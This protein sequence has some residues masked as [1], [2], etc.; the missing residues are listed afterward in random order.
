[1]K[2]EK[3]ARMHNNK[4]KIDTLFNKAFSNSEIKP[5]AKLWE[6]IEKRILLEERKKRIAYLTRWGAGLFLLLL[7]STGSWLWFNSK[8]AVLNGQHSHFD[9]KEKTTVPTVITE[10]P[11]NTNSIN[12]TG[13]IIENN[14]VQKTISINKNEK[15]NSHYR[16]VNAPASILFTQKREQSPEVPLKNRN[17]ISYDLVSNNENQIEIDKSNHVEVNIKMDTSDDIDITER[18]QQHVLNDSL[19]LKNE[20]AISNDSIAVKK[21]NFLLSMNTDSVKKSDYSINEDIKILNHAIPPQWCLG[22]SYSPDYTYQVFKIGDFLLN[23]A[24]AQ[25]SVSSQYQY[26]ESSQPLYSYT[27]GIQGGY[28]INTKLSFQTGLHYSSKGEKTMIAVIDSTSSGGGGAFT[29][30]SSPVSPVVTKSDQQVIYQYKFIDV[31]LFLRY[32]TGNSSK[33]SS[34]TSAGV[35]LNFFQGYSAILMRDSSSNNQNQGDPPDVSYLRKMGY[36]IFISTG[37][38]YKITSKISLGGEPVFTYSLTP[39]RYN[40]SVK[41]Y[42]YSFGLAI[43]FRLYM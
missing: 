8:D 1:M 30:T 29:T 13:I 28:L 20:V 25:L 5:S 7:I 22:L 18:K 37:I 35:S 14:H 12:N 41:M 34:V 26:I 39:L 40:P 43:S 10:T 21:Q 23:H 27:F 9:I 38:E 31:P 3:L 24:P 2:N 4:S 15:D 33:I 19:I 16:K 6:N 32:K 36:S 17:K 11:E 42:P